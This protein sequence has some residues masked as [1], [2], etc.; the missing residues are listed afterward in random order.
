MQDKDRKRGK[1]GINPIRHGG[2]DAP[3]TPPPPRKEM[4][5]TTVLKR[6]GG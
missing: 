5:L 1:E 2:H 4:F 6:L 3:P